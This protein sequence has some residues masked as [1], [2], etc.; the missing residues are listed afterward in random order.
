MAD[1]NTNI[2]VFKS[3]FTTRAALAL[4]FASFCIL[5][6]HIY[7]SLVSGAS[8][9]GAAVYITVIFF[10]V[11]SGLVGKPLT[12]SE[13]YIV[14][15]TAGVAASSAPF[16]SY[17]FRSFYVSGYVSRAFV[18]PF[19]GKP[20]YMVIPSWWA[21]PWTSDAYTIRSFLHP[22]WFV[23][24]ALGLILLVLTMVQQISL[25]MICSQMFI[26][27][28]Q[29]RFPYAEV[30]AR[31]VNTLSEQ[32]SEQLNVFTLSTIIGG[33]YSL[34]LYG[35]PTLMLGS[36]NIQMQ[37]IPIPW[38]DLTTGIYGLERLLPGGMFGIATDPILWS[39]GFI[40]PINVLVSMF[41]GSVSVWVFGNWLSLTYFREIFPQWAEEWKR[42]MSL[43]L[44][45]QRSTLR[46]WA[47]IQLG[48]VIGLAVVMLA[49]GYKYF[50][51]TFKL[52]SKPTEIS[53]EEGY[54]S[55]PFILLLYLMATG[56]SVILLYLFVPEFPIWLAAIV[57]IGFSFIFAVVSTWSRGETGL[58]I[59]VP[60][61]WR[62]T[63]LLSG[64]Q[65]IDVWYFFPVINLGAGVPTWVE[66]IKTAYLTETKPADFY[67][68]Y[69]LAMALTIPLSFIYVS[70][71][72]SIA[73]I[74]SSVYPWAHAQWPVEVITSAMW[75]T[76]QIIVQ[77]NLIA[78][79]TAGTVI[80]SIL[81]EVLTKLVGIP[82]SAVGLITGTM[83]PPPTPTAM[84]MGGLIGRFVLQK[85]FKEEWW[86]RNKSV[87]VAGVAAGTGTVTGIASGIVMI[88]K[89]TWILPF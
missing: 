28:N 19:S 59:T 70:F 36:F 5:P 66:G 68:A 43:S 14:F 7:L 16:L 73:P 56:S 17:V 15:I 30:N 60:N 64:Y 22:D 46:I 37:I 81:G 39:V 87:I 29:L 54:Y 48:F 4:L 11:I 49:R 38:I 23:P 72:W 65:K 69:L 47:P 62:M 3:G 88:M 84:L 1:Q 9:A 27:V 80:I 32:K 86:N 53:R 40:L 12:R 6:I 63:I 35:I 58:Q 8:L 79:A 85:F 89:S 26:R 45:W 50:I 76:R 25:T 42:G 55:L 75:A 82:F 67:K 21:P 31:I 77:P 13:I 44:I 71:F 83:S 57:S 2:R 52:L 41:I 33:L 24:I 10:T 78:Y 34:V 20:L 18:D 61:V 51:K 74:P